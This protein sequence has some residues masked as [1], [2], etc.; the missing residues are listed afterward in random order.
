MKLR[1]LIAVASAFLWNSASS[2]PVNAED[3]VT[4]GF[5]GAKPPYILAVKPY[6]E[7]DFDLSRQLGIE[8][9]LFREAFATVGKKIKPVYMNFK[10]MPA[11][12]TA[13][14]ID[15]ASIL[16]NDVD[17]AFYVSEY[18]SLTDSYIS[19]DNGND[20]IETFNDL[21]GKR[22]LA[23]QNAQKFL[24]EEYQTAIK[25]AKSYRE[26]A[27]QEKQ[28]KSLV[29][30]RADVL[31]MDVSIFKYLVKKHAKEGQAFRYSPL[32]EKPM[33]FPAGFATSELMKEFEMG[34]NQLKKTG[35]YEEIYQAYTE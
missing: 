26:I 25:G 7:K 18:L 3:V 29:S 24:P 8:V 13:G 5:K 12:I 20:K 10:R 35:R 21:K 33:H 17:G 1:Y 32:F 14:N 6:S 16:P 34:L 27:D 11:E 31:I 23:F 19:L 9:D 4:V 28:V 15:A 30:D 2:V 22:V